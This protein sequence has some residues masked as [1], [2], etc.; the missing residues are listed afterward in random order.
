MIG[1]T[2]QSHEQASTVYTGAFS[3]W[4]AI[5]LVAISTGAAFA[6]SF[7]TNTALHSVPSANLHMLAWGA[8]SIVFFLIALVIETMFISQKNFLIPALILNGIALGAGF[9]LNFNQ[10]TL[11]VLLAATVLIVWSGYA[12]RIAADDSLKIRFFHISNIA[13]KGGVLAVALIAGLLFFDIFS[14]KPI[15]NNNPILPQSVFDATASVFSSTI[16]TALGGVDFSQSLR[17][18]STE[19]LDKQIAQDPAISANLTPAL[20]DQVINKAIADYQ[21]RLLG[22]TGVVIDPDVKLS[23]AIY[24]ALLLKINAL[25]PTTKTIVILIGAII[26]LFTVAAVSP[27]IRPIISVISYIFYEILLAL[28]FGDIVFENRSKETIVLP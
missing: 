21:S 11:I 2:Q 14:L 10:R 12:A 18:V 6:A 4:K 16:G 17:Q 24:D 9:V 22:I 1:I 23:T 20:R 7:L 28:K 27:L 3:Y 26:F 13:L 25:P 8:V 5:V 15:D 19:A